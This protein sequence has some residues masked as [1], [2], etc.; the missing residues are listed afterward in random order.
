MIHA[1]T[2]TNDRGESLAMELT[3]PKES[4]FWVINV[5]G[6]GPV[7]AN[8]NTTEIVTYDGSIFNSARGT[9]RNITMQLVFEGRDVEDVR[10]K[11]YRYFPIKQKITVR[12]DTDHRQCEIDGYVE[13]N[14]PSIFSSLESADISIICPESWFRDVSQEGQKLI[15]F[16]GIDPL[17]EFPFSNE[18]LTEKLIEFGEIRQ[19]FEESIFYE[20]EVE[21]GFTITVH[22]VGDI[23]DITIY[24]SDTL[25]SMTI[26]SSKLESLTGSKLKAG[27]D[28]VITTVKGR[29][30]CQLLREATYTNVLNC[31][32]R[33]ADWFQLKQGENKFAYS[34][35]EGTQNLH[36]SIQ[37]QNLF[38]GV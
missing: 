15:E 35:T 16:F 37:V 23:G 13:S 31:L 36:L 32:D 25:E 28:L 33:N 6:L 5:E 12:V 17:F 22:A 3:K 18:S 30:S 8:I 9:D 27:D 29:K 24:N 4:G 19:S 11:S 34:A 2:V 26:S 20:G 10:H 1:I 14:E 38:Q 21:T 7:Q